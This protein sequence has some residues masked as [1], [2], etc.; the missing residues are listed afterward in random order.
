MKTFSALSSFAQ[1]RCLFLLPYLCPGLAFSS[2]SE[3]ELSGSPSL[4][5]VIP[6]YGFFSSQSMPFLP[7]LTPCY[8][9]YL[10]IWTSNTDHF[11]GPQ[12]CILI[13]SLDS[14]IQIP[15]GYFRLNFPEQNALSPSSELLFPSFIS[16]LD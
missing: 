14:S 13:C 12:A 3:K 8:N 2:P 11:S 5:I 9:K 4:L 15:H 6:S 10:L 1:H 16:Y 7:A